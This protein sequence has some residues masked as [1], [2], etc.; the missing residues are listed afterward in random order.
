MTALQSCILSGMMIRVCDAVNR[1]HIVTGQSCLVAT[2]P[3]VDPE[4]DYAVSYL[5]VGCGEGGPCCL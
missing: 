5:S 4:C 3:N 2:V 1:F